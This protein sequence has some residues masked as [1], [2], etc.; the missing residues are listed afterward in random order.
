[1]RYSRRFIFHVAVSVAAA[2]D[3]AS[4]NPDDAASFIPE[5]HVID[6][7]MTGVAHMS[8]YR[9]NTVNV[10][11]R[12]FITNPTGNVIVQNGVP[13][14]GP[15]KERYNDTSTRFD[16]PGTLGIKMLVTK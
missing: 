1:M 10:T 13:V 14:D 11:W 16:L 12:E 6:V 3:A 8:T 4:F 9:I 7:V 15:R 2:T 5:R